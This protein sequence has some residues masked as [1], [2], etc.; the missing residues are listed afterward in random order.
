MATRLSRWVR[1]IAPLILITASAFAM[2]TQTD[3]AQAG[4]GAAALATAASARLHATHLPASSEPARGAASA[5]DPPATGQ[6][7]DGVSGPRIGLAYGD[8]L[9]WM[10]PTEL[11]A[12]LDDAAAI[13]GTVR[14]D[15]S[16]ANVQHNGREAWDWSG[17]DRVVAA[18]RERGLS[19]IGVLA[20]TPAWARAG[21]CDS[22]KCGPASAG[23][24]A[25]F[26]TAAVTRYGS[27]GIDVWEIWN[28]PN[29]PAFWA[30]APRADA[31][32][33]LLEAAV[34]AI[35]AADP[36]ATVLSGGLA[37][38]PDEGGAISAAVF[39]DAVCAAGANGLVDGVAY[40]PYTYPLLPSDR[41]EGF[42]TAWNAIRDA[43][44][45]LR[46]VLT[47][48]GSAA[49]PIWLTEYGAPTGGPGSAS[50]GSPASIDASTT[51]VTEARQAEIARDSVAAA[52]A[53]PGVR[54]LIWYS[55]RDLGGSRATSE[56][57]YGLRRAD[58]APKP[59]FAALRAAVAVSRAP[60]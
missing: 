11:G 28:E 56:N 34:P 52:G 46:G 3:G 30:P 27:L 38:V 43:P 13:G 24:F 10:E 15:V 44:V 7:P 59:A 14:L 49:M 20:Y 9:P 35:R 45:N 23:D 8:E 36:A 2:V 54:A 57:F 50:D 19:M 5:A 51:H 26:A 48:H 1:M 42:A 29:S 32:V 47:A 18:A 16:W 60:R 12:A 41:P 37:A 33:R 39:L 4:G 25:R 31:Y 17:L 40:H 6:M 55:A 58:G 53:D 22:D 21:G